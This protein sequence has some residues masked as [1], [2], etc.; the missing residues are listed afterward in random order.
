MSDEVDMVLA[1]TDRYIQGAMD[2]ASGIATAIDIARHY[3]ALPKSQRPRTMV[4]F[5]EPDHHHGEYGR[6]IFIKDYDWPKVAL[7]LNCEHT[8]QS[9]LFLMNQDLEI[10]NSINARRWYVSGSPELQQLVKNSF[11][12]FNVS[13]YTTPERQAGGALGAYTG[14]APAFHIIDHIIYHTTLDT[15]EMVPAV[16]LAYSERAFL[17]IFDRANNM[18][19][20]QLRGTKPLPNPLGGPPDGT[21]FGSPGSFEARGARGA[22]GAGGE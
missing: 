15:P 9:Q 5:H 7:I 11:K 3:A 12:D 8:S 13:V 16:G 17:N 14:L 6:S 22:R 10:G 19:M 1:H 2:N 21:T 4:F 20:A 18:T